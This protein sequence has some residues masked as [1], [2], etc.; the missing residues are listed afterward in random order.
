MFCGLGSGASFGSQNQD[1]PA[2]LD[3]V[4][5]LK[6]PGFGALA[7]DESAVGAAE[8]ADSP[9]FAVA[10]QVGV[11]AGDFGVGEA[12]DVAGAA[13]DADDS[14]CQLKSRTLVGP[15]HDEQRHL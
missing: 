12:D 14:V 7:V 2:D 3:V 10:D 11:V 15:L 1:R 13:A 4:A 8:V 9:G 6:L 5:R